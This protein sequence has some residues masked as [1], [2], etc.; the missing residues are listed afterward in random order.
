M[1][2]PVG[3]GIERLAGGLE[4]PDA[5]QRVIRGQQGT[6][7]C[8]RTAGGFAIQSLV[9]DLR[10]GLKAHDQAAPGKHVVVLP[11]DYSTASNSYD[12]LTPP[13]SSCHLLPLHLSKPGLTIVAEDLSD[14][15]AG[16]TGHL[17]IGIDRFPAQS[18]G[19]LAGHCGLAGTGET[20]DDQVFHSPVGFHDQIVQVSILE[21]KGGGN[22]KAMK[23]TSTLQ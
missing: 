3:T 19:H 11:I 6:D 13:A 17:F 10:P 1:N 9:Y 8:L 15:L 12:S 7:L 22:K 5:F 21:K 16:A 2:R 4:L 23:K 20:G 18:P 14:R